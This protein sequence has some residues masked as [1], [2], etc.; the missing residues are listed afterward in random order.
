V[1]EESVEASACADGES[2]GSA[3]ATPWPVNTA[4]PMPRATASPP[5]RPTN[6]PAPMPIYIPWRPSAQGQLGRIDGFCAPA[7][8]AR[9]R[10]ESP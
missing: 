1:A 2:D 3:D 10:C 8:A 7:A 6:A 9:T 5:I 4:A